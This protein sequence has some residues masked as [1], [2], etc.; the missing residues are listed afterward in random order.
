MNDRL[1]AQLGALPGKPG[2]YVFRDAAGAVLYIGKAK[3][4]RSRVRNYFQ[5]GGD[6]RLGMGQL[7]ARVEGVEVI[8][9]RNEEIGRAS[10]R[11][12][13]CQYV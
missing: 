11:E 1:E 9:T 4:L 2:V 3:S 8:V 13:V 6:G 7:V 5:K 10:C 12:R